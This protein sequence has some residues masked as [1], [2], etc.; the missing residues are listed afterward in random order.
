[1]AEQ[2]ATD[3]VILALKRVGK[4][5]KEIQVISAINSVTHNQDS[6]IKQFFLV[7]FRQER[8]GV[9]FPTS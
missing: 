7:F 6:E 2:W 8:V 4:P 9:C 1:M 3:I 5:P